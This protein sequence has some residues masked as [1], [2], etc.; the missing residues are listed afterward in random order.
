MYQGQYFT[1]KFHGKL[2]DKVMEI[3]RNAVFRSNKVFVVEKN[4]LK[5]KQINVLKRNENTLIFNGLT[6]GELLATTVPVKAAE[7]MKVQILK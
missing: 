2:I 6:K 4:M 1:A 5:E 7:N 3:P